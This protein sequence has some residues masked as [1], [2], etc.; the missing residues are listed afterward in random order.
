MGGCGSHRRAP[1]IRCHQ[2]PT[3]EGV[4]S[5]QSEM[6][7]STGVSS[8]MASADSL[9]SE[10][11]YCQQMED[12]LLIACGQSCLAFHLTIR[13]WMSCHSHCVK[14]VLTARCVWCFQYFFTDH[15]RF[16]QGIDLYLYFSSCLI[17]V[18]FLHQFFPLNIQ[19]TSLLMG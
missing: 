2:P 5:S 10:M 19:S 14:T 17:R 13:G 9:T 12:E 3:F 8:P 15:A 18:S 7:T 4:P 11:L 16:Y 6:G 1:G